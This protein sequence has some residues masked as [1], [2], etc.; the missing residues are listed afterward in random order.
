MHKE[1]QMTPNERLQA[2]MTGEE[3]DRILAMPIL[4]SVAH[5][6]YGIT[7]K[8]R[9]ILHSIKQKHKLHVMK[10]LAMI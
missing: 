3:M 4:V 10:D 9:G 1:D 6:V 8:K 2:F 7:H 5:R